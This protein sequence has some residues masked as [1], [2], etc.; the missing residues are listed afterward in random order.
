MPL[1][2]AQLWE[3]ETLQPG[4][5][6]RLIDLGSLLT[7]QGRQPSL[8]LSY[9]PIVQGEKEIEEQGAVLIDNCLSHTSFGKLVFAVE[10]GYF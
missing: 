9:V 7:I 6:K 8:P 10:Q 3:F 4:L 1:L 5:Q 2:G